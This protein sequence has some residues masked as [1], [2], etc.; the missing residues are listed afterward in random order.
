MLHRLLQISICLHNFAD[1]T[2]VYQ[3]NH[4]NQFLNQ[5]DIPGKY[6]KNSLSSTTLKYVFNVFLFD[7]VSN[8]ENQEFLF[9][10]NPM[11]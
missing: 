11:I 7:F 4:Q 10:A 9:E 8:P 3:R 2:I 5:T 1:I 6:I